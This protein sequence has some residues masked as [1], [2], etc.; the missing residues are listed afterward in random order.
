M[1]GTHLERRR[2]LD[3]RTLH[4]RLKNID[5]M[6]WKRSIGRLTE[7]AADDRTVPVLY[8]NLGNEWEP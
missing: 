6:R 3:D 7:Q 4:N 5:W 2:A 8:K 1:L